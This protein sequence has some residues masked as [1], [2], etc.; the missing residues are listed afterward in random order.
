M[1][2]RTAKDVVGAGAWHTP[3]AIVVW[4]VGTGLVAVLM[5][6]AEARVAGKVGYSD[7]YYSGKLARGFCS[8]CKRSLPYDLK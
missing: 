8:G 6:S 5:P 2:A 3:L 7:N 1:S 4:L